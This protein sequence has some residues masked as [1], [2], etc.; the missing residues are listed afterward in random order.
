MAKTMSPSNTTPLARH[1]PCFTRQAKT[2]A[3]LKTLSRDWEPDS[4]QVSRNLDCAYDAVI[5]QGLLL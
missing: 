5:R 1:R 3:A 4:E 2:W